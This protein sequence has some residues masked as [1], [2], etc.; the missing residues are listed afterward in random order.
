MDK[1]NNILEVDK[2]KTNKLE[3]SYSNNVINITK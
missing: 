2:I 3:H 1:S